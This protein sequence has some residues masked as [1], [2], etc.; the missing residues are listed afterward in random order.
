[1]LKGESKKSMFSIKN[2]KELDESDS[3]E[4]ENDH[5]DSMMKIGLKHN[6]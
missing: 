4:D 6:S 3:L 5:V 1:M 2:K